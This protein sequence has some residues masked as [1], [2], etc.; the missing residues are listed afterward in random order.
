M[1]LKTANKCL[2]LR[3]ATLGIDCYLNKGGAKFVKL[4]PYIFEKSTEMAVI[5]TDSQI[6]ITKLL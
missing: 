3:M 6:L 4:F 5:T 1:A 2:S